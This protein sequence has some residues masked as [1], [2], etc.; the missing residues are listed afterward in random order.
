MLQSNASVSSL[1]RVLDA[2]QKGKVRNFDFTKVNK[3]LLQYFKCS[4]DCY[5]ACSSYIDQDIKQAK[6]QMRLYLRYKY[7]NNKFLCN[8]YTKRFAISGV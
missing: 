5:C 1:N 6:K 7:R 4:C 8:R 3:F 2:I